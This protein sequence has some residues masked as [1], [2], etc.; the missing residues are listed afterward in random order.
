VQRNNKI[1][2]NR[3]IYERR[4][5][6]IKQVMT[7]KIINVNKNDDLRYV[8]DLMEKYDIT[9]IPVMDNHKLVGIVTDNKIADKLGSIRSKGI[10]AARMHASSVIDKK[11]NPVTPD[12]DV[13]TILKTV[14]EPGL[15]MLPVIEK[16]ELVGVI[17]K[18]DLLPLIKRKKKI[19]EVMNEEIHTVSPGDRVVHAR[20][21]LL[22]NDIARIPVVNEGKV[23]GIVSDREIAF[24]F[25]KVKKS[26]SLGQQHYRIREL[27]VKDVMKKNVVTLPGNATI[28]DAADLMIKKDIGCIPIVDNKDK[29]MGMLTRTDLLKHL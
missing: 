5:M 2:E 22:D 20:R 23:V 1:T 24:A 13:E 6:K 27:L 18:A 26:F 7:K 11:F 28:K 16:E 17:T 9:K 25:A 3:K 4:K 19:K 15:T 14:G 21:I 12:D 10:P 29:I 8:L